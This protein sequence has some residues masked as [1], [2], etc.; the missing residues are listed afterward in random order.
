MST[1]FCKYLTNQYRFVYGV[2]QP[3]CW[4]TKTQDLNASPEEIEAYKQ[5]LYA[6]DDWVPECDFCK[7]REDKGMYSPRQQVNATF[8]D[9]E[10]GDGISLEFQIDRECNGGCLICGSWNST[11]W[12]QYTKN[13]TKK[14]FEIK[15]NTDDVEL[16]LKQVYSTV[17]LDKVKRITFLGG[18]PLRSDT[19]LRIL[20]E[21]EKVSNLSEIHLCYI[22]N[23]SARPSDAMVEFWRQFK[24]VN[25]NLSI[26]GIGQH[27]NYLRWPLQWHQVDLKVP[28]FSF[29]GSYTLTPFSAY[30]HDKYDGWAKNFFQGT[31]VNYTLMF[32]KPF[33]ANG[34]MSLAALP[35]IVRAL[36]FKKYK[37]YPVNNGH[38]VL[39]C[40]PQYDQEAYTKFMEYIEYHDQHRKLNWREVF[41]EIEQYFK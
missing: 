13:T 27:F 25:F 4:Y 10:P 38:S 29:T 30:Y 22:T 3:C 41:P 32:N 1:T 33:D 37:D 2:L 34:V 36:M 5:E 21:I 14:V 19:H 24:H 15:K 9:A 17:K 39:K 18:E 35:P 40:I 7:L 23:G 11:T 12:D 20:K 31:N 6:I 16:W 8:E 28:T 26:D